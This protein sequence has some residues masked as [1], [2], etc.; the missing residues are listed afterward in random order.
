MSSL[1]SSLV[2]RGVTALLMVPFLC[3]CVSAKYKPA[4]KATPPAVTLNLT[5]TDPA[6]SAVLHSAIIFQGPGSWKRSAYWD[7][8]VISV[9]NYSSTPM[10]VTN[11]ELFDFTGKSATPGDNP[12]K[13]EKQSRSDLARLQSAAGTALKIGASTLGVMTLGAMPAAAAVAGASVSG[14]VALAGLMV[15]PAFLVGTIMR[16]S[17]ERGKIDREFN[18]RRLELPVRLAPGEVRQGSLFFRISPGPTHVALHYELGNGEKGSLTLPLTPLASL[19]LTKP[20][21]AWEPS[22]RSPGQFQPKN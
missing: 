3:G 20:R 17:S 16:N 22:R 9:A 10:V 6:L 15:D 4:P 13:V 19:H 21:P 7:E 8:Y 1:V 14:T 12:W 18:A 2:P 5:A 11:V